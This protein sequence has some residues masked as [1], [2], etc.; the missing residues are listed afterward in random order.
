MILYKNVKVKL[1]CLSRAKI[2]SAIPGLRPLGKL[3]KL[4]F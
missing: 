1:L 3:Q 4:Y 2:V